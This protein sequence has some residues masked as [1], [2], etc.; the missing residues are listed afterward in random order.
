M[1]AR[2]ILLGSGKSIEEEEEVQVPVIS[3]RVPVWRFHKICRNGVIVKSEE[4]LD[5]LDSLGWTDH[6]GKIFLL[7]GHEQLFDGE[8]NSPEPTLFTQ[9][10]EIV[11]SGGRSNFDLSEKKKGK[12]K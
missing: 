6:P 9:L 4:E 11:E 5:R 7:P 12:V 3:S 1:A 2:N 10:E 8:M